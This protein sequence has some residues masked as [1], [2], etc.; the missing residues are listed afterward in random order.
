MGLN[1]AAI[2]LNDCLSN[3]EKPEAGRAISDAIQHRDTSG[4]RLAGWTPYGVTVLPCAH[5]DTMQIVAV[6]GNTIRNL[7]YGDCR[8][9]D[10]TLLRKLADKMGYRLVR[11]KK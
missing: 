8:D 11:K 4:D 9:D 5:A 7:G 2:I 1:T 10:E 3:L 6:G